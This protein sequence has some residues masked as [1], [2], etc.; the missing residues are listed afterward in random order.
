MDLLAVI[1][2]NAA[3][4]LACIVLL[5][6]FGTIYPIQKLPIPYAA[7]HQKRTVVP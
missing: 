7:P 5:E 3:V 6:T 1:L 4:L 2:V